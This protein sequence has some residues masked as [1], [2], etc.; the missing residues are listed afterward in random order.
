MHLVVYP[1]GRAHEMAKASKEADGIICGTS[2]KDGEG[3][4]KGTIALLS[5]S[6]SLAGTQTKTPA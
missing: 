5:T 1:V 2:E 4:V 3:E 6:P